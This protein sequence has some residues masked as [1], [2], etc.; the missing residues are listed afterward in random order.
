VL[1][2]TAEDG[3]RICKTAT[4]QPYVQAINTGQAL[5]NR[6]EYDEE[7]LPEGWPLRSHRAFLVALSM[8]HG[9]R[10]NVPKRGRDRLG[11][12]GGYSDA[13]DVGLLE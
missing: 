11:I 7:R 9:H 8:L 12:G 4:P 2:S 13:S 1:T 3:F 10:E 6:I 5:S